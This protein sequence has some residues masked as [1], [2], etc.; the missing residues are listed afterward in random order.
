MYDEKLAILEASD[1][2]AETF[3]IDDDPE[4]MLYFD[5][6]EEMDMVAIDRAL[7]LI[8]SMSSRFNGVMNAA[9]EENIICLKNAANKAI[10]N[11]KDFLRYYDNLRETEN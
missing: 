4:E 9:N 2:A 6:D 10:K 7:N 3:W 8:E 1:Y 11:M 5:I